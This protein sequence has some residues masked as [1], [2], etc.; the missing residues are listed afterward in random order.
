MILL[1]TP[2]IYRLIRSNTLFDKL[3]SLIGRVCV[4]GKKPVYG[5]KLTAVGIERGFSLKINF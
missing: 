3:I 5:N 4:P 1:L 2:Y